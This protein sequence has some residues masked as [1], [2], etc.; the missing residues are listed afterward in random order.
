[1]R[2]HVRHD[3]W[4]RLPDPAV[5]AGWPPTAHPAQLIQL[6]EPGDSVA[7][8]ESRWLLA[9]SPFLWPGASL[10]FIFTDQQR[11]NTNH[12]WRENYEGIRGEDCVSCCCR[13]WPDSRDKCR[14]CRCH[15]GVGRGLRGGLLRGGT[16]AQWTN[17]QIAQA[18]GP[19][20][21]YNKVKAES[22]RGC[23]GCNAMAVNVQVDLVSYAIWPAERDRRGH[24]GRQ[25]QQR[26]EPGRCRHVRGHL[27]RASEPVGSGLGPAR[28]HR[29]GSCDLSGSRGRLS[30]RSKGRS[31]ASLAR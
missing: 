4:G 6:R 25:G 16:H 17:L 26:P 5:C 21:L 14:Y 3:L 10:T 22:V 1:M 23:Q 13:C 12:Q 30:L 24:C 27:P 8:P 11:R 18:F 19:S 31:M 28:Q 7:W 29:H 9:L 2:H 15:T 20:N